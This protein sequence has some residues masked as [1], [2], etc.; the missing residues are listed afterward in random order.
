M[1]IFIVGLGLYSIC[2]IDEDFFLFDFFVNVLNCFIFV[3][4][5]GGG[6]LG[7]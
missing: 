5:G 1:D 3:Y 4:V 6:G 7:F 2:V